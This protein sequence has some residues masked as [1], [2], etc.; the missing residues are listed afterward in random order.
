[1]NCIECDRA[2]PV[3][4]CIV[5]SF[6]E[7]QEKNTRKNIASGEDAA[8]VAEVYEELERQKDMVLA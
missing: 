1:M 8:W 3:C 6:Q 2:V 4:G 5:L 7:P